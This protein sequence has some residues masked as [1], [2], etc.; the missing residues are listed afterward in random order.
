M[1]VILYYNIIYRAYLF[2]QQTVYFL[3]HVIVIFNA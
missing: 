3:N 2:L 1:L